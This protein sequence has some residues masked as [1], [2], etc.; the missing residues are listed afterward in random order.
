MSLEEFK[1]IN[2]D[3][4]SES[5]QRGFSWC[6]KAA[7][8]ATEAH[9][10]QK[11]KSDDSSYMVHPLNV[12]AIITNEGLFHNPLTLSAAILHDTL[13]DTHATSEQIEKIFGRDICD[14]VKECT[15]D[16]T[17]SKRK[18][19]E[20]QILHMTDGISYHAR[21]VKLA[22]KLDNLRG[23]LK[24]P[25]KGWSPERVKGYAAW[26]QRVVNAK[27]IYYNAEYANKVIYRLEKLLE[28]TLLKILG[29]ELYLNSDD[30][31]QKYLQDM[32]KSND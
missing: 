15:D 4:M 14:I 2:T 17:L 9:K 13:E 27:Q 25:P 3:T 21:I 28:E 12:A 11:R 23:L 32:E 19:K 30:L 24:T 22:D 31:Y 18:R 26:A 6:L 1:W 29:P 5:Y 20:N 16:K 7:T 10:M 8:F